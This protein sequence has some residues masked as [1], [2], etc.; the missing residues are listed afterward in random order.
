MEDSIKLLSR[1]G[2]E[3]SGLIT[4]FGRVPRRG[5]DQNL[6]RTMSRR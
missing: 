1:N 4:A 6:P 3:G 5:R 2:Y